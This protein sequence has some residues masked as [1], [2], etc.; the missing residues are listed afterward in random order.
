VLPTVAIAALLLLHVPPDIEAESVVVAQSVLVPVTVNAAGWV[1][2]AVT[3]AV[4]DAASVTT[5]V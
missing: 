5:H 4:A 2:V 1:I 3:V